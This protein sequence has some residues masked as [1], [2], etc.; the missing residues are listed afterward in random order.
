MKYT[1]I[2]F[3]LDGTITDS[4]AGILNSIVYALN[5]MN[6]SAPEK[7]SLR[8]FIGPPLKESF[9]KLFHL[10]EHE[11]EQAIK[12]YREY[13]EEIGMF[14]NKIYTGIVEVLTSLQ[15]AGCQ[16]YIATSKPEIYAKKILTYFQLEKFFKGIYGASLDGIRSQKAAVIHYGLEQA[17]ITPAN[18]T[19][20]IGD[21]S[22]D[23]NGARENVL[24]SI[25]VLYGFGDYAELKKARATYIVENP[26]E[27]EQLLLKNS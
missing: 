1:N 5:K 3:D 15:K 25:G 16:L 4:E 18:G 19:I 24:E 9:Q 20:M 10:S 22:H 11:A 7:N 21:R 26:K 14:E 23:I 27:I 13:Y 6:I 17:K 8:V 2:L 12:Y